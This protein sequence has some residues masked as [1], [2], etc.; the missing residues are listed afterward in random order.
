MVRDLWLR[1]S[2][3]HAQVVGQARPRVISMYLR[4]VCHNNS[5]LAELPKAVT[6]YV[7][8]HDGA[9]LAPSPCRCTTYGVPSIHGEGW[10]ALGGMALDG[11]RWMRAGPPP[12]RRGAGTAWA[13]TVGGCQEGRW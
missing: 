9:A 2:P 10:T 3:A 13:G 4:S 12:G 7:Y 1:Q 11:R 8:P 5:R 6:C